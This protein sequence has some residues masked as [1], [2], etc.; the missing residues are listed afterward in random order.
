[1]AVDVIEVMAYMKIV[2][3]RQSV[4]DECVLQDNNKCK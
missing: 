1:M 3:Y 2:C 4:Y